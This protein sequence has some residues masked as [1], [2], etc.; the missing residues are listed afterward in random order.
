MPWL[1]LVNSSFSLFDL[2]TGIVVL[3][4]MSV[5]CISE[6]GEDRVVVGP[7]ASADARVQR[8]KNISEVDGYLLLDHGTEGGRPRLSTLWDVKQGKLKNIIRGC[9]AKKNFIVLSRPGV[10]GNAHIPLLNI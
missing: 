8:I 5:S 2:D 1:S 6:D 9:V 3:S 10:A 4:N 7:Q